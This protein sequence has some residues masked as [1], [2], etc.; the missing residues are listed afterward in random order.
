[1]TDTTTSR[2]ATSAALAMA[3]SA[4]LTGT[5]AAATDMGGMSA[6]APP[7]TEKCFGVAPKGKNSCAA[8]PGTNC[9]GTS[10]MDHQGN[11]WMQVPA[12]TCLKTQSSTSPTGFG[13]LAAFAEKKS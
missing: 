8:G 4:A 12:G 11:V 7:H 3:L 9:A 13:Q 10:K 2:Y 5:A 1:M 6:A